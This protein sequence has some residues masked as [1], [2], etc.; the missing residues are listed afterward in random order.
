MA[1][2]LSVAA[3]IAG[4]IGTAS[5]L[6]GVLWQIGT[7]SAPL[8][9]QRL[10][11]EISMDLSSLNPVLGALKAVIQD[12]GPQVLSSDTQ[13][14]VQTFVTQATGELSDLYQKLDEFTEEYDRRESRIHRFIPHSS[15]KKEL[16]KMLGRLKNMKAS[17]VLLMQTAQ[18]QIMYGMIYGGPCFLK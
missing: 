16:E 11:Q 18:I 17:L 13:L 12:Y 6:N 8:P 4:L 7:Q 3:S 9:E 15:R 1:D 10:L 2:P 14:R 5:K